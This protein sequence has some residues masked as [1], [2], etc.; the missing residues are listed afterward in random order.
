MRFE[1][2][3]LLDLVKQFD[4]SHDLFDLL[5]EYVSSINL[6]FDSIEMISNNLHRHLHASQIV[7]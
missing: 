5:V 1:Y 7:F 3:L 6:T 4:Y 2:T